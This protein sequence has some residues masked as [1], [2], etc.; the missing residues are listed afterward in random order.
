[1]PRIRTLIA[2][3]AVFTLSAAHAFAAGTIS[4]T[5]FNDYNSNGTFD[6][7]ATLTNTGG[8]TVGV[9]KDVGVSG[10]TVTAYDGT[11]AAVG[12]ATSAADG[13]YSLTATGTGPY[14]IEF[15]TIPSGFKPS[16]H[17]TN[18]GTTVQFVPD[19]VST[20]SLIHI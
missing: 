5:V 9:A 18:S 13:T 1:M 3:A 2:T 15:T 11:G 7:T 16:F 8:G 12:T 4:G 6:T 20:L 10:V 17:G 14:R 19:G